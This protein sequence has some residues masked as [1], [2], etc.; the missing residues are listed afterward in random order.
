V[1]YR[2]DNHSN[3]QT[4]LSVSTTQ[5]I[6]LQLGEP[7]TTTLQWRHASQ[8]GSHT[9]LSDCSGSLSTRVTWAPE[10]CRAWSYV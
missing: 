9:G 2:K 3:R 6:C 10:T 7:A 8:P 5:P 1:K 4:L